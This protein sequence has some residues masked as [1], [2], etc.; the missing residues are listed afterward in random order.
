MSEE[1]ILKV[2]KSI[3]RRVDTMIEKN[4]NHIEFIYC[5]YPSSDF[6]AYN[7]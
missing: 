6:V 3:R 1:F 4:G 2:Y 7:D 5:F